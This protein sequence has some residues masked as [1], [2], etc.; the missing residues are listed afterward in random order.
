MTT[1]GA[2]EMLSP[3]ARPAELPV[4]AKV[5][6]RQRALPPS[7]PPDLPRGATDAGQGSAAPSS[8]EDDEEELVVVRG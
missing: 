2:I 5:I 6:P 8:G 4:K 7:V 3:L 1:A